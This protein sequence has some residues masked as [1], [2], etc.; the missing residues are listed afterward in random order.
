MTVAQCQTLNTYLDQNP[1]AMMTA[2]RQELTQSLPVTADGVSF[3]SITCQSA[4]VFQTKPYHR[5]TFAV[6]L[7]FKALYTLFA[8]N[9]LYVTL[10]PSVDTSLMSSEGIAALSL[11][12]VKS[13]LQ[14]ALGRAFLQVYKD[15]NRKFR[16]LKYINK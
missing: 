3:Q 15:A 4:S 5:A 16:G 6:Q 12:P 13:A 9:A 10:P 7:T 14:S 1:S 11:N 2:L 8:R